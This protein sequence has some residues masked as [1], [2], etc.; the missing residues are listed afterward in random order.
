MRKTLAILEKAFASLGIISFILFLLW[1]SSLEDDDII[2]G[3]SYVNVGGASLINSPGMGLAL[4]VDV[5]GYQVKKHY[6]VGMRVV[7]PSRTHHPNQSKVYGYFVLDTLSGELEG[8]MCWHELVSNLA[9]KDI[10]INSFDRFVI[11]Y[12]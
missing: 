2:N 11:D 6:I 9:E 3:Y 4:E 1:I 10:S 5:T 12:L 7:D 8:G